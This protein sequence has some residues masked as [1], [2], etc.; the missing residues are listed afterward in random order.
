LLAEIRTRST[1][2]RGTA[3][4]EIAAT[5]IDPSE[6]ARALRQVTPF[7]GALSSRER[8]AI[9]RDIAR[10]H[11]LRRNVTSSSTSYAQPQTSPMTVV[12]TSWTAQ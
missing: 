7:A 12:S 9:A 1:R 6:H 5:L 2:E 3:V 11:G 8:W 4:D 10:A